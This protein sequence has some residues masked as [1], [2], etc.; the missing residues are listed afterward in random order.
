MKTER[1]H[2]LK[3]I[4]LAKL[5]NDA[6]LRIQPYW[7]SIAGVAVILATVV[8]GVGYVSSSNRADQQAGGRSISRR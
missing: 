5:V 6:L 1:R 8:F 7:R 3:Q 4:W 2:D